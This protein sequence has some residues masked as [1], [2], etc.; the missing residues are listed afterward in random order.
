MKFFAPIWN[1][2]WMGQRGIGGSVV[3]LEQFFFV[4]TSVCLSVSPLWHP[5]RAEASQ[6]GLRTSQLGLS[7]K[8]WF[9]KLINNRLTMQ[10]VHY[11]PVPQDCPFKYWCLKRIS[12]SPSFGCTIRPSLTKYPAGTVIL[13]LSTALWYVILTP[14]A[15]SVFNG[16]K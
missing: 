8:V 1:P 9:E 10:Q 12:V 13:P 4:H 6:H 14:Y 3:E 5:A 16:W 15:V 2:V 7:S 11:I